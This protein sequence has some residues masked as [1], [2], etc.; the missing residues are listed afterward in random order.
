MS[1]SMSLGLPRPAARPASLAG[2][3]PTAHQT[4]DSLILPGFAL[5][6]SQSLPKETQ[7]F[8][9]LARRCLIPVG[10]LFG[11]DSGETPNV[12]GS[13]SS[14]TP[15]HTFFPVPDLV[16]IPTLPC[17]SSVSPTPNTCAV[18]DSPSPMIDLQHN[19]SEAHLRTLVRGWPVNKDQARSDNFISSCPLRVLKVRSSSFTS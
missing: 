6:D 2:V 3:L 8:S 14:F 16:C 19:S 11:Q 13:P 5:Q 4:W 1:I 12:A 18:Q 10:F 9:P 17:P 15:L 7:T